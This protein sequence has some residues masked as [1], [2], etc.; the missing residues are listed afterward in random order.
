MAEFTIP[1]AQQPLLNKL[2]TLPDLTFQELVSALGRSPFIVPSVQGLS[3]SDTSELRSAVLELYDVRDYFDETVP[4]FTEGIATGL[5]EAIDFPATELAAFRDRLTK[6][7]AITPLRVASKSRSLKV[8]YERRFCSARILTDTRPVYVDSP[9]SLPDAMMITHTL[10][11]TF[12]DDTGTLRE[13]YIT[14]DDDDLVTLRELIDRAEK[15][16][17]SLQSVFST[18]NI[19]I[20]TP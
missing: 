13:V 17:K 19:Q 11:I 18:A 5:R 16:T 4:E 8:E 15:K 20:A 2:R 3:A 7:L 9:S 14:M 6:V 1:E 10:R 12:H